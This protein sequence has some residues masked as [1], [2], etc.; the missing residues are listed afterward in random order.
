MPPLRGTPFALSCSARENNL[1]FKFGRLAVAIYGHTRT[2]PSQ[3]VNVYLLAHPRLEAR[4]KGARVICVVAITS[5]EPFGN[6][7]RSQMHL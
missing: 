7:Q 1:A 4:L 6:P 5:K 2:R 3:Y